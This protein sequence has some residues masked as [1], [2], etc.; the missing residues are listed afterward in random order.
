MRSMLCVPIALMAFIGFLST[1]RVAA[2]ITLSNMFTNH[3]VL[4]RN[5]PD[6]VWGWAKPG[7]KIKVSFAGRTVA[8]A[9]DASGA[10]MAKL[11]PMPGSSIPRNLTISSGRQS[12]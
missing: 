1:T 6:P 12:I 10:W 8:V 4:Q 11:P 3:L 7:Q 2:A 9:A 5:M